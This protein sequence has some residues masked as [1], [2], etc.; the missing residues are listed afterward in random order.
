MCETASESSSDSSRD[1]NEGA[2]SLV[3]IK[4]VISFVL[5]LQFAYS[6]D[7]LSS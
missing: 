1:E 2:P 7:V 3:T 4:V 5:V 6:N